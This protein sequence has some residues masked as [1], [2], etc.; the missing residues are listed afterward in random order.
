MITQFSSIEC[1]WLVGNTTEFT[2]EFICSHSQEATHCF[3]GTYGSDLPGRT[4]SDYFPRTDLRGLNP[5][6]H[7]PPYA[8]KD[9]GTDAYIYYPYWLSSRASL[10]TRDLS[11]S[12]NRFCMCIPLPASRIVFSL[13][14]APGQGM[15]VLPGVEMTSWPYMSFLFKMRDACLNQQSPTIDPVR[16]SEYPYRKACAKYFQAGDREIAVSLPLHCTHC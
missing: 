10:A 16:P 6:G 1:G 14:V 2:T 7:S 4:V 13:L 3:C 12:Q 5:G 9:V 15:N 11:G 8:R